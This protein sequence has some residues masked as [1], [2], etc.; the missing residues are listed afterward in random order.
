MKPSQKR[1]IAIRWYVGK[2]LGLITGEQRK[3]GRHP[4][5]QQTTAP[6]LITRQKS[7]TREMLSRV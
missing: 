4:L 3:G 6:P 2:I 1:R 5:S 7:E